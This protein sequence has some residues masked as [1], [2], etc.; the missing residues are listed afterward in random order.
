MTQPPVS[1]C[2]ASSSALR[3]RQDP[4]SLRELAQDDGALVSR[5]FRQCICDDVVQF[6][7][8]TLAAQV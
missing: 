7:G 4:E 2:A 6:H 8:R 3:W 5:R 1:P